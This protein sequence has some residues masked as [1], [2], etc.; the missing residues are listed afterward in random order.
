MILNPY[1]KLRVFSGWVFP[2][3]E[4]CLLRSREGNVKRKASIC[5]IRAVFTEGLPHSQRCV[6]T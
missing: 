6:L 2:P 5:D 1:E 4:N 3:P